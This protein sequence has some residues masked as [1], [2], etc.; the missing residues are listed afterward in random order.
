VRLD[1]DV[2]WFAN[3]LMFGGTGIKKFLFLVSISGR[4]SSQNGHARIGFGTQF[5]EIFPFISQQLAH[6]VI[7]GEVLG[8]NDDFVGN[9]D[10][11]LVVDI[12]VV[13]IRWGPLHHGLLGKFIDLIFDE[14]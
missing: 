9:L 11:A 13:W 4:S 7:P 1:S 14:A 12:D 5:L 3:M 10:P 6:E 8:G 2:Q